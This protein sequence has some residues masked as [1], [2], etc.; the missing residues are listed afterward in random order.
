MKNLNS[1]LLIALILA[2]AGLY[3]RSCGEVAPVQIGDTIREK[4]IQRDSLLISRDTVIYKVKEVK[5]LITEYRIETDTVLKIQICDS[6]VITCDSLASQFSRQD[7]L[8]REQIKDYSAL[9]G[10][11][12]SMLKIKPKR[13]WVIIPVPIPFR[14]K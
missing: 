13:R 3:L 5:N 12:D 2:V 7:S 4:I 1:V 11:Q 14:K 9:V 8:F 6:I 10:L